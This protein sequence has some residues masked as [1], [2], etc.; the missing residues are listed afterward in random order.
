VETDLHISERLKKLLPPLTKE[1]RD[2]LRDNIAGDEEVFDPLVY[3]HDGKKNVVLDGM[4]RWEM[5]KGWDIAYKTT[6]VK[7]AN[8]EE[9]EL[10][11]LNHQLGRRNLLKPAAIRKIRGELY[12]RLKRQDEGHGDQK[13]ARQIGGPI[14][15]TA[16]KLAEKAG[17]SPR[18]IE[19]DG[20]RV[21]AV[22]TLT[23]PAQ[24]IAEKATD[25]EVK[26]LTNLSPSEQTKI[27]RAVRVGQAKTVTQAVKLTGAKPKADKKSKPE[28][29]YDRSYW[30][31]QWE[32]SIGP[33]VRLV[34]KIAS[35]VGESK[36]KS[37]KAIQGHLNVATEE[38][39]EWMRIR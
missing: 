36:S 14:G 32:H 17:V 10:W 9:A 31:K 2:L 11:I 28:K 33:L 15:D 8:Y 26:L 37:H 21:A 4:H 35:G 20:A 1:E 19:R 16:N 34:D 12:N 7:L 27:A 6:L 5:L 30:F 18:T 39:M 3:W 22:E 38:M 29:Q 25:A 24:R 23:E 13:S